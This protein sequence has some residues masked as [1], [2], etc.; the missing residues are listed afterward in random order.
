MHSRP[1]ILIVLLRLSL[2]WMFLYSGITKI[3]DAEWTSKGFLENA[4]TFSG[5]FDW[6]AQPQNLQWV[7]M[8][9]AWGQALIGAGLMLGVFT[10]LSAAAGVLLMF[11]YYLPGLDFPFV[12]HSILVDEHVIYSLSL[13]LLIRLRAGRDYSIGSLF[14][15]RTPYT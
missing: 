3:L 12:E 14:S 7:D 11:L 6:L 5:F 13:L 4:Q 1:K 2:G 9:N 8:A 10:T 15:R